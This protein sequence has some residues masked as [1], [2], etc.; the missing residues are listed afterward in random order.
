MSFI[1]AQ[2]SS[3]TVSPERTLWLSVIQLALVDAVHNPNHRERRDARE[4]LTEESADLFHVCAMA[5]IEMAYLLRH[6]RKLAASGGWS[7]GAKRR[8]RPAP[9]PAAA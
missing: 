9:P 4:W 2:L 5:G 6:T 7:T 3:R 1:N 8:R